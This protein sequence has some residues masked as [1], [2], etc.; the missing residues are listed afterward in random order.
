M[1]RQRP[2]GKDVPSIFTKKKD[3][4]R[5]NAANGES[6]LKHQSPP[7]VAYFPKMSYISNPFQTFSPNGN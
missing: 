6:L 1:V 2:G 4:E 3:K 7:P 5:K